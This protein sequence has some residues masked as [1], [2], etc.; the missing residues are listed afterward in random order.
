MSI[1]Y[2]RRCSAAMLQYDVLRRDPINCPQRSNRN[3]FVCVADICD[4]YCTALRQNAHT[5]TQ[6]VIAQILSGRQG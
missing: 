5:N 1:L 6:I 3:S 4:P 2:V